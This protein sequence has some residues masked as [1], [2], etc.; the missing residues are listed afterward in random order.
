[1]SFILSDKNNNIAEE[2]YSNSFNVLKNFMLD[3]LYKEGK[4]K[5]NVLSLLKEL[6]GENKEMNAL[7][8]NFNKDLEKDIDEQINYCF[9]DAERI[10]VDKYL[11]WIIKTAEKENADEIILFIKL[12][13]L[14][15]TNESSSFK[16]LNVDDF[17]YFK[18]LLKK[19]SKNEK[20]N[21]FVKG[22]DT[23][24]KPDYIILQESD[25]YLN[26]LDLL[27]KLKPSFK[28]ET[29]TSNEFLH[30][31]QN[32]YNDDYELSEYIESYL[33]DYDFEEKIIEILIEKE[34][35][36]TKTNLKKFNFKNN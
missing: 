4:T 29:V 15:P 1:M 14:K 8:I 6:F 10:D 23:L 12:F 3:T 24:S 36:I 33:E 34:F 19:L 32:N 26:Y 22:L 17:N 9:L 28:Q 27:F 11:Q 13:C 20:I 21:E 31:M 2:F 35:I 5:E 16:V 25:E 18:E 30:Y 7:R